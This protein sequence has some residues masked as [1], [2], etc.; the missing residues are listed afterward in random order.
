MNL[1]E[2]KCMN[3]E[4]LNVHT[5]DVNGDVEQCSKY[6]LLS[7]RFGVTNSFLGELCHISFA[8]LH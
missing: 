4:L 2:G 3:D 6:L 5:M 8:F 1:S 7:S